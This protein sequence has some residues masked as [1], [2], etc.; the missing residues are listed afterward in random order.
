MRSLS[1]PL[2]FY[3]ILEVVHEAKTRVRRA[4]WGLVMLNEGVDL[5]VFESTQPLKMSLNESCESTRGSVE[6]VKERHTLIKRKPPQDELYYKALGRKRTSSGKYILRYRESYGL[7]L[8]LRIFHMFFKC[9]Y[10]RLSTLLFGGSFLHCAAAAAHRT[11]FTISS[12]SFFLPPPQPH[13]VAATSS[14]LTSTSSSSLRDPSHRR[15]RFFVPLCPRSSS[16]ASAQQRL[17]RGWSSTIKA[18]NYGGGGTCKATPTLK[19]VEYS[20]ESSCE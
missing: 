19:S 11:T 15:Y 18:R 7:G 1:P 20:R 17:Q 4:R 9:R 10:R 14:A 12:L 8:S 13:R 5:A 3:P 2:H 6:V 16:I